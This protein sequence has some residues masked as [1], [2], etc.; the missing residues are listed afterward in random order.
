MFPLRE[1]I[2][3]FLPPDEVDAVFADAI[4]RHGKAL[5]EA[6]VIGFVEG[7]LNEAMA[8]LLGPFVRRAIVSSARSILEGAIELRESAPPQ[9]PKT[10][11]DGATPPQRD[12]CSAWVLVAASSKGME[13]GVRLVLPDD[14]PGCRTVDDSVALHSLV[15]ARAPGLW[16]VDGRDPPSFPPSE[17]RRAIG[18]LPGSPIVAVWG[19]ERDYGKRALEALDGLR[20][21]PIAVPEDQPDALL[22]LVRSLEGREAIGPPTDAFDDQTDPWG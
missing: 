14:S 15:L 4:T 16:I 6:E 20:S 19:P 12:R 13:R 18:R 17:I 5:D 11:A 2:A 8:S 22:D 1:A 3:R 7:P 9:L 21:P 10:E